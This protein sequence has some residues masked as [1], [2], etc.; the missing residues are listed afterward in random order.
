MRLAEALSLLFLLASCSPA[1]VGQEET[2]ISARNFLWLGKDFCTGGQPSLE[3]LSKLKSQGVKTLLNL[4]QPAETDLF[5]SEEETANSLGLNY[6]NIP[7]DSSD[8]R[9]EQVEEFLRI[10]SEKSHHP[11]FIH[12]ASASRVGG[13]WIIYRVLHDGMSLD[14][15]EK[16]A[17][18]IGLRAPRLMEFAR[19][20]I[21]QAQ[22]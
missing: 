6:F 2:S 13:F 14:E 20:Y 3:D 22:R 11:V 5:E 9:S 7:V 8:L 18:R 21:Q 10:V 19:D 16:E 15:A 4:R 1:P 12:C 17:S